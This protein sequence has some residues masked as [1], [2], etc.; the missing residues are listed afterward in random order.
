MH[1]SERRQAPFS[2]GNE[3]LFMGVGGII[4]L[5][6]VA[7]VAIARCG[8][9][10]Q[11]P[12]KFQ[13][14]VGIHQP[15]TSPSAQCQSHIQTIG[16]GHLALIA[17]LRTDFEH[18]IGSFNAIQRTRS[19]VFQHLDAGNILR[20]EIIKRLGRDNLSVQHIQR[21]VAHIAAPERRVAT[22]ANLRSSAQ[23][24][25][26]D[27]IQPRNH[28]LK[29]KPEVNHGLFIEPLD[30]DILHDSGF[31]TQ[32]DGV[33]VALGLHHHFA[34]SRGRFLH[35]HVHSLL[36]FVLQFQRFV[37]DICEQKRCAPTPIAA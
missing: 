36:S 8:R 34:Y 18:T 29:C 25:L 12:L 15:N 16:D 10:L 6:I 1:C 37:T 20:V 27:D 26:I 13:L 21:F 11:Q 7:T 5:I 9:V 35:L 28:A 17:V 33:D 32:V 4:A 30:V 14:F 24:S 19:R 22:N 3:L 2:L 23:F 31:R